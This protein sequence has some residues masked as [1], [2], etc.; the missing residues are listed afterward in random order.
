MAAKRDK[1]ANIWRSKLRFFLKRCTVV[2][3]NRPNP[4]FFYLHT[5]RSK[6]RFFLEM[7][8]SHFEQTY[9]FFVYLY[10]I[11]FPA[12]CKLLSLYSRSVKLA[13]RHTTKKKGPACRRPRSG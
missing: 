9:P 10:T 7:Y 13:A 11:E 8:G 1:A 12:I 6:R 4:S 2:I 3:S 5:R